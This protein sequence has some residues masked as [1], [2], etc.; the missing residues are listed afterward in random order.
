MVETMTEQDSI[1][2]EWLQLGHQ[3]SARYMQCLTE[4]NAAQSASRQSIAGN[5][6][7][8]AGSA[9]M[10]GIGQIPD[11]AWNGL[12][13]SNSSLVG[14]T[15]TASLA[16]KRWQQAAS[17]ALRV[18]FAKDVIS[19]LTTGAPPSGN[20]NSS[21]WQGADYANDLLG[22]NLP[23]WSMFFTTFAV[24]AIHA[25]NGDA[26]GQLDTAIAGFNATAVPDMIAWHATDMERKWIATLG[27]PP[28]GQQNDLTQAL[29]QLDTVVQQMGELS[30]E[31]ATLVAAAQ[32]A[33]ANRLAAFR[34]AAAAARAE[35]ER[36][37]AIAAQQQQA[38]LAAQQAA[39]EEA[40]A[41]LQAR[42]QARQAA[43]ERARQATEEEYYRARQQARQRELEDAVNSSVSSPSYV[44]VFPSFPMARPYVAPPQPAYQGGSRQ[45]YCPVGVPCATQ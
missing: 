6:I 8:G 43:A 9:W 32:R 40:Q 23:P 7:S 1:T 17:I 30:Q 10:S 36:Q 37:A 22:A 41:Q 18:Q 38:E 44:P 16:I 33:E 20:L 4:A 42:M 24:N 11:S 19:A 2:A 28:G 31:V 5:L 12:Q 45:R 29:S 13:S 34:A 26:M 35:Q 14:F 15:A 39:Q 21:V 25:I 3:A 27:N